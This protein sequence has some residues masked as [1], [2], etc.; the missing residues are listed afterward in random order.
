MGTTYKTPRDKFEQQKR[1]QKSTIS[2]V[3]LGLRYKRAFSWE[4][5]L[6]IDKLKK[7]VERRKGKPLSKA[8]IYNAISLINRYGKD[9]GVYV[10]SGFGNV[11]DEDNKS[12]I[13]YRYFIPKEP[14]EIVDE[15]RDLDHKKEI[16][17]LKEDNIDYFE[18]VTLPQ[19]A[20][21]NQLRE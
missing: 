11:I 17:S 9:T 19:E 10:R 12:K 20:Q 7:E 13:R 1:K 16:I 2:C 14:G 5:G 8:T 6:S 18:K 15:K 21:L 4:T 3:I